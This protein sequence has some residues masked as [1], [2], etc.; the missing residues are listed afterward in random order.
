MGG[1]RAET[2]VAVKDMWLA[3]GSTAEE[4]RCRL[5]FETE[6]RGVLGYALRRVDDREDAGLWAGRP[7]KG[8]IKD[9]LGCGYR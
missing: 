9:G 5:L 6:A 1:R 3:M 2:L 8:D 4:H 7:L